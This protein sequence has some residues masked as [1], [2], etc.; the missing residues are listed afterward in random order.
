MGIFDPHQVHHAL[1]RA[2]LARGSVERIEHHIGLQFGEPQRDIALHVELGDVGPAAA[3]QR[4]GDAPG[5]G[6][7]HFALGRPAAHQHDDV[8]FTIH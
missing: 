6:Q 4:I 3:P 2:V 8:D 5:A 1:D 7:R